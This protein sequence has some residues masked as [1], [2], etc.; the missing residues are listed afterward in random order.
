MSLSKNSKC[1]IAARG[2]N[3]WLGSGPF[4]RF[5]EKGGS[6]D[7]EKVLI[8]IT[9]RGVSEFHVL[10]QGENHNPLGEVGTG[11][12]ALKMGPAQR[13]LR[14]LNSFRADG[15]FCKNVSEF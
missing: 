15:S 14:H 11:T 13:F 4:F 9:E 8:T 7:G 6:A 2:R 10:Q 12:R 3:P 5:S 1:G